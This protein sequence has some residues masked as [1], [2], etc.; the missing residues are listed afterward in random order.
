M[1]PARMPWQMPRSSALSASP[2]LSATKGLRRSREEEEEAPE[3]L[4]AYAAARAREKTAA[5]AAKRSWSSG[6][7]SSCWRSFGPSCPSPSTSTW[8]ADSA[9]EGVA[10]APPS[11][12]PFSG[13]PNSSTGPEDVADRR[14]GPASPVS[15]ES[16]LERR[17]A[18]TS[19]ADLSDYR[20]RE[21]T[22]KRGFRKCGV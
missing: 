19:R 20:R 12:V 2:S 18:H 6:W 7:S 21:R 17:S 14:S 5:A 4:E 16:I 22:G 11:T 9:D 13:S 8:G 3:P 10:G 15:S 1:G